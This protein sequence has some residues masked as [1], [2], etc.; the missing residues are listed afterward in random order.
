M[1]ALARAIA[2]AGSG[3][4]A[5]AGRRASVA[6]GAGRARA[7]DARARDGDVVKAQARA[8]AREVL[9]AQTMEA[10]RAADA[11]IEARV[12]TIGRVRE[13]R[14]CA[15]YLAS[16]R[17]RE[18]ATDGFIARA[19]RERMR[20]FVPI[21]EDA[22]T[23]SMRMVE[24]EDASVDVASGAYG[25][26]EPRA[27][28]ADGSRRADA[29]ADAADVGA[30]DVV[31]VPGFEFGEDGRRLGRGGGYYDAFLARY[32]TATNRL[33]ARAPL[34]VALA[35]ECQIR[36]SGTVPFDAHDRLVDVVVTESRAIACTP[37]G[38]AALG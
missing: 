33:G 8:R 26:P 24:I 38:V 29:L 34:V 28:R 3:A 18:C 10:L 31:V 6:R 1:R 13:A 14:A 11:A 12:W 21:V 22:A 37:L 4:R 9:R 27:T 25:L 30:L 2:R 32:E 20:V 23:S 15:A 16:A 5:R 36:P 35:Y 7:M 17:L 19:L